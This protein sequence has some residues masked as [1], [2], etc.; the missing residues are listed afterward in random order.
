MALILSENRALRPLTLDG[1]EPSIA[2]GASGK[3]PIIKHFFFITQ[4]AQSAAV[5]QF[6]AFVKS[7]EGKAILTQTGHWVP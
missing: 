6:I 7:P 2:N 4:P 3:Y 1:V 5:Q